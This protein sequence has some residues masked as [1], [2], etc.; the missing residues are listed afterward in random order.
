M[1]KKIKEFAELA[2]DD[3]DYTLE[4]DKQFL[5]K[6]AALVAAHEREECAKIAD[7][8]RHILEMLTS[9]PL[10]SGAAR[11]IANLIRARGEK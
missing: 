2:G 3:W 8:T 1:N 4:S 7:N 5:Q 11:H 6:F 10:Q 9:F